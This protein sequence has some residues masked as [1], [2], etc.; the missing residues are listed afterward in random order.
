[1]TDLIPDGVTRLL[2]VEGSD[3]K[4][5]FKRLVKHM[6]SK[7]ES[8]FNLA[9]FKIR[10]FKGKNKLA[11]YMFELL[12]HQNFSEVEK[13]GIV[14][15]VDYN[16]KKSERDRGAPLRTLDSVN[17]A[18]RKSFKESSRDITPPMFHDFISPTGMRPSLS[19]MV[20]PNSEVSAEGSLETILLKSLADDPMM[21][22][23]EKYFACVE[24]KHPES[25]FARNR[26]DKN[27]LSVFLSGK[28]ILR[29]MARSKDA[30]REL[31][32]FMYNMK[33]WNDDIF[34]APMFDQAKAFLAQ[35]LA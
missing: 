17:A 27:R 12:Q 33:W 21:S 24:E 22:C 32:R 10:K 18:I 23:V 3:D 19:L 15:D 2:L 25:E 5:F 8:P 11:D 14:R 30:T 1:M 13:I 26:M 7:R 34:E 35:L 20:M 29:D 28:L 16:D 31:P 9:Q 4:Q 6:Q